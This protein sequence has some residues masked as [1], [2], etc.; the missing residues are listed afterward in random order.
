[1]G[2]Q[3][4]ILVMGLDER[5]TL[6][7]FVWPGDIA[8]RLRLER[9]RYVKSADRATLFVMAPRGF[10]KSHLLQA[11][12]RDER[13]RSRD[14]EVIYLAANTWNNRVARQRAA[15]LKPMLLAADVLLIDDV[16]EMLSKEEIAA[17]VLA[18]A[19]ACKRT[20]IAVNDRQ[21]VIRSGL[22]ACFNPQHV[23]AFK[24]LTPSQIRR[25]IAQKASDF[26]LKITAQ[27][28]RRLATY[29]Y[30]DVPDVMSVVEQTPY[31]QQQNFG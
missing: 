20:I 23:V 17:V 11:I 8:A 16:V 9:S 24:R 13:R 6:E 19:K 29:R 3:N 14:S 26:G 10:G 28:E 31:E 27:Q 12:A 1:M 22:G 18:R 5:A 7:R 15:R 25:L 2:Q 21:E 4:N 30:R